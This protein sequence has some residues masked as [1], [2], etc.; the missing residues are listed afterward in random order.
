M[1]LID[2]LVDAILDP[3]MGG[4]NNELHRIRHR[5]DCP[6]ENKVNGDKL[7]KLA[8]GTP[9]FCNFT[10]EIAEHTGICLGN[11]IVHL[12]GTGKVICTSPEVFL[13]RL[14]GTNVAY[15]IFY[16]ARGPNT[17]LGSQE[18]AKRAKSMIDTTP[19]YDLL[20]ANCHQF[21]IKCIL[22]EECQ[23][24]PSLRNLE[25]AIS[26]FFQTEEWHWRNWDGFKEKKVQKLISE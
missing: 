24:S 18:I 19:G 23:T 20:S 7:A 21:C 14:N 25:A 4:P 8:P 2:K 11:T 1:G 17:P 22:D 6:E 13:A 9:V 15:D 10:A 16:A 5:H 26:K 3:I 12:D